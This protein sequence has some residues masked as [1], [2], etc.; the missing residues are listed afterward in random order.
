[1]SL[2][3]DRLVSVVVPTFNAERHL[4]ETLDSVLSQTHQ[5]FEVIVVDDGS[6][7]GTI[8]LLRHRYPEVTLVE[9]ANAGV[10]AARNR[11][12]A[13]ARGRYICFLDQDDVWFPEKL[14][15]QVECLE[16]RPEVAAVA[17]PYVFWHPPADGSGS[18]LPPLPPDPGL[19]LVEGFDGWT[20]HEFLL[21]C[22][23]LTS[24]TMLRTDAVRECGGFDVALPYAEDWDLWLRVARRH[25]FVLLSWPPVLYRQHVE[26]GSRSIRRIDHRCEL[27]IRAA[28]DHGLSSPDGRGL[29]PARFRAQIARY[30]MEFGYHHLQ[31]GNRWVGVRSL[32]HSW[33]LQPAQWHTLALAG[34]GAIG[35]R[36]ASV[37]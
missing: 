14:A 32:L 12:L 11:G 31:R 13:M 9:Q 20:Y 25:P 36:P 15:R 37:S 24:A 19:R 6:T 28:R 33:A 5:A 26:Q 34:L 8:Q 16:F 21:D 3:V 18:C 4:S 10:G 27:L 22:W 30:R 1:M 17:C 7:D 35:W 29:T 2:P 23:A